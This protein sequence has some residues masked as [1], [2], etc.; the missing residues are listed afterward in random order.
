[1]AIGR[2]IGI[3]EAGARP[4][5]DTAVVSA[6]WAAVAGRDVRHRA[7]GFRAVGHAAPLGWMRVLAIGRQ[8]INTRVELA[9][10][11]CGATQ[12]G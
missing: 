3:L 9:T 5:G 1:M 12:P 4:R 2:I 11:L 7:I 10:T 8:R 6:G